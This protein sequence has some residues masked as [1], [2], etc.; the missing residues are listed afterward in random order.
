MDPATA[1]ALTVRLAFNG[2]GAAQ[3][4]DADIRAISGF[5]AQVYRQIEAET[6]AA[7]TPIACPASTETLQALIDT[8]H[9]YCLAYPAEYKVEKPNPDS[10]LLVIGGLLDASNPRAAIRVEDAGA[11]GLAEATSRVAAEN[12]D[13][14]FERSEA[15]VG[16]EPAIVFDKLPGQEITRRVLLVHEGRLYTLDFAPA[17]PA[18]DALAR[19]ETLYEAVLGS[20]TLLPRDGQAVKGQPAASDCLA[21]TSKTQLLIDNARGFC[22]LHPAGFSAAEPN[23]A[24]VVLYAGSLQDVSHPR[25]FIRVEDAQARTAEQVADAVVAEATSGMPGYAIDRPF[26]VTIGYEPAARLDG[27]PGQDLS[28]QVI[29]VHDG[30]AYKL[31]FVPADEA[32]GDVYHE[33]EALYELAVR[34]FRFLPRQPT[35]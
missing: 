8:A 9:G 1:D 17:D 31:V 33:M 11:G 23:P 21:P 25:L 12:R 20:F 7:T 34:S 32:Q 30:R 19:M 24:E 18:S 35:E 26:G 15:T 2:A 28:R 22:L 13:F 4:A 16:G 3:A 27:V 10:T 29:V 14:A 5:A 6:Q